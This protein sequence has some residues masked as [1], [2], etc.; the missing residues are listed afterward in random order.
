MSNKYTKQISESL[1]SPV[2]RKPIDCDVYDVLE[3]FGVTCPAIQHAV[4]K[5]LCTGQ[6][7]HK[8]RMTDLHEAE[9]S[10]RR[11]QQLQKSR[12]INANRESRRK[13]Q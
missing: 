11:A 4:K 5:L 7:G 2:D 8:D 13:Q 3:A 6:R 12:E 9:V 1:Y 10:I